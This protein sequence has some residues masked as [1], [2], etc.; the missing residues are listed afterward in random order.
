MLKSRRSH[1]AD[2]LRPACSFQ[3]E[4]VL[5]PCPARS[6]AQRPALPPRP[7]SARRPRAHTAKGHWAACVCGLRWAR[8]VIAFHREPARQDAVKIPSRHPEEGTQTR[9]HSARGIDHHRHRIGGVASF[10]QRES[11]FISDG[12]LR[13]PVAP[14]FHARANRSCEATSVAP[15]CASGLV[16]VAPLG[17]FYVRSIASVLP[18]GRPSVRAD[19]GR[20]RTAGQEEVS[21]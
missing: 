17:A 20:M 16:R 1:G 3:A 18:R 7:H 15:S 12:T 11:F 6:C 10:F 14:L 2:P 8:T 4:P 19:G 13:W 9:A 21:G 5:S